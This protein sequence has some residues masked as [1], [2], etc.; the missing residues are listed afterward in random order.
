MLRPFA[1]YPVRPSMEEGESLAG[2]IS[3]YYGLNGHQMPSQIHNALRSLYHGRSEKATAAFDL[4][5]LVLGN[6]AALDR[7]WWL[8]RTPVIAHSGIFLKMWPSLKFNATR[9][10]PECLR[11]KGFHFSFWELPMIEACPLHGCELL[12][13]CPIC[14]HGLFWSGLSPLW[15]CRCGQPISAMR[16]RK[17]EPKLQL[18]AKALAG[19]MDVI[20]PPHFRDDFRIPESDQYVFDEAHKALTWGAE[21]RKYFLKRGCPFPEPI[22]PKSQAAKR[23]PRPGP[24][25]YRL[26]SEPVVI[27]I[28]RLLRVL[29]KRFQSTNILR[30]VYPNDGLVQAQEF[31][32]KS[33][34]GVV[35]TKIQK[36]LDCFLA[37][38]AVDLSL[39]L[40]VW[41]SEKKNSERRNAYMCEFAAWW[42]VL[43]SRIGDL[44]PSMQRTDLAASQYV[45]MRNSPLNESAVVDIL[46]L[47]FDAARQRINVENF[48][49]LV[50]WWRI[51]P[52]LRDVGDPEELFRRIGLHLVA[53]SDG[54]ISFVL[55]LIQRAHRGK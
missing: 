30:F 40:F 24:W 27:L 18:V 39:S 53:T 3:R 19:S 8:G 51:P 4:V 21:F 17:A 1:D 10:C 48:S 36:T 6:A 37:D 44:D 5:Q 11:E 46:N 13:A 32:R 25:E 43:A 54:E 49:E 52:V 23:R 20:L 47:L 50:Y 33:A 38:Y 16:Y 55:D 35:Q 22:S 2:Y 14:F 26:I 9:F 29:K 15:R 42:S 28:S 34:S 41:F 31:A 12:S 7:A 45:A